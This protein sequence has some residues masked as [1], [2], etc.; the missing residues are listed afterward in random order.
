MLSNV[1]DNGRNCNPPAQCQKCGVCLKLFIIPLNLSRLSTVPWK[2]WSQ[3]NFSM[4]K[5]IYFAF[6]LPFYMW[7]VTKFC[8][9]LIIR[10]SVYTVLWHKVVSVDQGLDKGQW[11]YHPLCSSGGEVDSKS[12]GLHRLYLQPYRIS[13]REPCSPDF[14]FENTSTQWTVSSCSC[15]QESWW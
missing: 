13:K 12:Y 1:F 5:Q 15:L 7:R 2:G 9:R 6:I 3:G 10:R 8:M 4:A 11:I 14:S